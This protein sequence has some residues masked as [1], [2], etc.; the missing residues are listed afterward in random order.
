MQYH[1]AVDQVAK[2]PSDA[3]Y[4]AATRLCAGRHR[5]A[6]AR[7]RQ[8]RR[9]QLRQL[10]QL[11]LHGGL[12]AAVRLGRHGGAVRQVGHRRRRRLRHRQR[13]GAPARRAEGDAGGR[14]AVHR[15]LALPGRRRGRRPLRLGDDAARR[16]GQRRLR[17]GRRTTRTRP[18]SPSTTTTSAMPPAP[19]AKEASGVH[20]RAFQRG[21]VLVNPTT[22][23]VDV[24]FG[25]TYSGSGL[26]RATGATL[27]PNTAL[28]LTRDGAAPAPLPGAAPRRRQPATT[29]APATS[30]PPRRRRTATARPADGVGAAPARTAASRREPRARVAAL[31]VRSA[32]AARASA[33]AAAACSCACAAAR[34]AVGRR[35]GARPRR[36]RPQRA[37]RAEPPRARALWPPRR[38]RCA[39]SSARPPDPRTA[40]RRR[41]ASPRRR[42]PAASSRA[43]RAHRR[44]ALG[45]AEQ[46]RRCPRPAPPAVIAPATMPA[47]PSSSSA[48][49]CTGV[50]TT[51]VPAASASSAAIG[52]ALRSRRRRPA[53]RRGR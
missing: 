24:S 30:R 44:A 27:A 3:A 4:S 9:P 36:P 15:D 38:A 21:L 20:R 45:V 29:T 6:P 22:A 48:I 52:H 18:G 35:V 49:P 42:T 1:Y 2:Y 10:G 39:S 8:A 34:K 25:G 31:R 43:A 12:L 13:L 5:P 28:V 51:G 47:R 40:A 17:A 16:R 53:G 50:L 46:R 11:P 32:A 14:Q 37:R 23:A 26:T 41:R 7:R 33:T 19:E